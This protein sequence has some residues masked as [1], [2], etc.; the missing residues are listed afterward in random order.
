MAGATPSS[1]KMSDI[2]SRLLRPALTSHYYVDINAGKIR[3][4]T[5]EFFTNRQVGEGTIS[6]DFISLSCS[7]AS[8]PGSSLATNEINDDHTG[9]TERHAYRRLYDDRI[10]FTFYVDHDHNIIKFFETWISWIVGE[11]RYS[12]QQESNYHYRIK[13]PKDYRVSI[14]V[15]KFERDYTKY[16]EYEFIDAYPISISSMPVSY[17]SSSLLKCTVSFTYSRYFMNNNR[18]NEEEGIFAGNASISGNYFNVAPNQNNISSGTIFNT[19]GD[20]TIG[21]GEEI[22]N[23][24]N[25]NPLVP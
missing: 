7:E 13:F 6:G 1:K 21:E 2:K 16:S 24:I 5:G 15:Q 3:N 8:L 18:R 22:I 25:A 14:F 19:I 11:R 9:V 12:E 4:K 10:D 20:S 17:D 23:A